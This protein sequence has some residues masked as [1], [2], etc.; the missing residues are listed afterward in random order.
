MTLLSEQHITTIKDAAKKLTGAKRRAFQAQVSIDYLNSNS[1][2]AEKTFGWDRKTVALGLNELRTGIVCVDNFKARGNKKMEV[3]KPHLEADIISLAEP[4]SQTD[5]KFQTAFKFTRITAKGMREAL[6][7]DKGWKAEDLPCVKTIGNILNR[8]GYRLRRVQKAK[9]LKKIKETDAIPSTKLRT[10]F[11]NLDTVNRASDDREDSL[12]ISIDTKAKVDLCDSSRGGTSRCKRAV[13]ADDHDMGDKSKLV[14]LGILDVMSGLLT[15]IFGVSFETSDFIV[16]GIEQ[17]W[18]SNKDQYHL[19]KQLVINLDNGPHNSSHRT[20]FMKRL[21]EFADKN[22]LEIVLAYYPPYHSKYNPIER[23]WGILENH[24]N[25]TLLNTLE[26][27]LEWAKSMTWKGLE[28]VVEVL[29]TIYKKG[30]RIGKKVFQSIADRITRH[31]LL[32]K[33]YVTIQPQK[34]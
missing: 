8:L 25:G 24:W 14:P 16:D 18:L 34:G 7:A 3:K 32:P 19:I 12:R 9:P 20:Q 10:G 23:C 15:I 30:V 6:I 28:P 17:W 5:P 33:Y 11:D 4:K 2:L 26:T 13:Q 31:L 21:T 22:D 1:R 29:E 27:T